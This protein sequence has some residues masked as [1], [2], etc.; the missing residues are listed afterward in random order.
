VA[1][2]G[3][4]DC[5][6]L[7]GTGPDQ[8]PVAVHALAFVVPHVSVEVPPGP[9]KSGAAVRLIVGG[10]PMVT[11]ACAVA[12]PPGPVHVS[13]YAVLLNRGP[14]EAV[15]LSASAPDHPSELAQEVALALLQVRV[16]LA[17]AASS[18]GLALKLTVG[19]TGG[20]GSVL[21]TPTP[22]PQ[23]ASDRGR[24]IASTAVLC[25]GDGRH[26]AVTLLLVTPLH[27]ELKR[28]LIA[29]ARM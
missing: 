26:I 16:A 7:T 24:K 22:P 6:P 10:V 1:A 9:T 8:L 15:P 2:S 3:P 29:S 19:A 23:A 11:V 21:E 20:G 12:D 18:V 4:V 5:V 27:H 28:H 17:P 25:R 14:V 13:V